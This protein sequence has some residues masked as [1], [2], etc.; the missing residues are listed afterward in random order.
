MTV[1]GADKSDA[2]GRMAVSD[3]VWVSLHARP[4]LGARWLASFTVH[5]PECKSM[6]SLVPADRI[7]AHTGARFRLPGGMVI[8]LPAAYTAGSR[9]MYCRNVYLRTGFVMPVRR[10]VQRCQ[11]PGFTRRSRSS[12]RRPGP[13]ALTSPAHFGQA[14][15]C[16]LPHRARERGGA[17]PGR[18]LGAGALQPVK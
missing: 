16:C 15:P 2:H 8:S 3:I 9:E 10:R 18:P 12:C 11:R 13:S 14:H 6:Q 1:E 4:V 7:W 5:M 17:E